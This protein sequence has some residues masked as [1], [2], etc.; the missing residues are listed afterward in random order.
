VAL[1]LGYGKKYK[2]TGAANLKRSEPFPIIIT[3]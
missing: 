1:L 3:V 2:L